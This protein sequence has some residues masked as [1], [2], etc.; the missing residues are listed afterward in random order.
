[1]KKQHTLAL[2]L[3]AGLALGACSSD[4]DAAQSEPQPQN[5]VK[6]YH[7]TTVLSLGGEGTRAL[8]LDGTTLNATWTTSENVFVLKAG[9]NTSSNSPTLPSYTI[10][11]NP[12]KH[13][14]T[15]SL[16]IKSAIK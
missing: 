1:M 8:S 14:Q 3:L 9:T 6:T 12:R 2:L 15:S 5:E 13:S 11:R 7:A 10:H 4:D 16:L